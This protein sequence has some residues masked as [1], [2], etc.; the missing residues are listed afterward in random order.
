MRESVCKARV[1]GS[2][3]G[4]S[5]A[6][7]AQT[8]K[9]HYFKSQLLYKFTRGLYEMNKRMHESYSYNHIGRT[10]DVAAATA[11]LCDDIYHS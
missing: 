4:A 1:N 11:A 8:N 9:K 6:H 5:A 2:R 10:R 3:G 7:S